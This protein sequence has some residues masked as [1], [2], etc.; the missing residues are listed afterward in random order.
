MIQQRVLV[1]FSYLL[2]ERSWFTRLWCVYL[3]LLTPCAK[4]CNFGNALCT[5]LNADWSSDLVPAE[6]ICCTNDDTLPAG[7]ALESSNLEGGWMQAASGSHLC[8]NLKP[9][10]YFGYL[11][12]D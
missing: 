4:E 1:T 6:S 5:F 9:Y 11:K 7:L 10:K 12:L 2:H 3:Y 8:R